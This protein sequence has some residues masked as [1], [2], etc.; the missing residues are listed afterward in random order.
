MM[1]WWRRHEVNDALLD[2]I[3]LLLALCAAAI[4][5]SPWIWIP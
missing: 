1:P 4:A 2:A 5:L 3:A